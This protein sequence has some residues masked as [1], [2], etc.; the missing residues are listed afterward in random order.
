MGVG[1]SF[2][3]WA[4]N[5]KR[6]PAWMGALQMEWFYRLLQEPQRWRRMLALPQFAAAVL[7]GG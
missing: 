3:V 6:A 1:G 4:G 7:R 5:K 2:D